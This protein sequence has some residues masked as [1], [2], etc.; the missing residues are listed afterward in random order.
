MRALTASIW[1]AA[2]SAQWAPFNVTPKQHCPSGHHFERERATRPDLVAVGLFTV[3]DA[4]AMSLPDTRSGTAMPIRR[5]GIFRGRSGSVRPD[6][7]DLP[8]AQ[9]AQTTLSRQRRPGHDPD[10]AF[11]GAAGAGLQFQWSPFT[12]TVPSTMPRGDD[13]TS[14]V[15]VRVSRYVNQIEER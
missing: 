11:D 8:P 10:Q 9:L 1:S 12:I 6:V 5:A 2:Y 13:S 15:A 14:R 7:I 3:S 4:M